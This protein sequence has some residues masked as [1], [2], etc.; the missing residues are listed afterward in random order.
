M[1]TEQEQEG[2]PRTI[3]M[4]GAVLGAKTLLKTYTAELPLHVYNDP[5]RYWEHLG[6]E[7]GLAK[8]DTAE[9]RP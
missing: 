4:R 1:R 6:D 2:A 7:E 5:H 9:G 8:E 3:R